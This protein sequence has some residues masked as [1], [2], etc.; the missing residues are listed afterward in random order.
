MPGLKLI[1]VIKGPKNDM[2]PHSK[3]EVTINFDV[4][5]QL[6]FLSP[7]DSVMHTYVILVNIAQI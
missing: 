6:L 2:D 7:C 4:L 3:G 5:H 1:H